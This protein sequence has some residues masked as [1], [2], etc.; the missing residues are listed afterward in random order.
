MTTVRTRPRTPTSLPSSPHAGTADPKITARHLGRQARIY[1]RQSSPTQVHRHP[2]SARRRYGLAERAQR[3]G[4]P[5]GQI[6]L[7]DEDRGK[8]GAGRA[9]APERDGLGR[10]VSAVG[11]GEVGVILVVGVSRRAR[12]SAEW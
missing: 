7:S 3:P 8:S 10:L 1:V 4:W 11:P 6:A 2:E 9:A 12:N 5:T